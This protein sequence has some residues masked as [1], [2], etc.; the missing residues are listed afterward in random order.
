MESISGLNG[1]KENS[2]SKRTLK[3]KRNIEGA[4][5]GSAKSIWAGVSNSV[6]R[7]KKIDM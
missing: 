5:F 3:K 1:L 6:S 7:I 4:R 2:L